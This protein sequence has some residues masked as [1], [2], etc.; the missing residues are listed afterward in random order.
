MLRAKQRVLKQKAEQLRDALAAL[1]ASSRKP[2]EKTAEELKRAQDLLNQA[3]QDMAAFERAMSE[4]FYQAAGYEAMID[5]ARNALGRA[6]R[7]LED[8]GD[9]LAEQAAQSEEEQLADK[10]EKL[11]AELA[12]LA[13][14]LETTVDPHVRDQLLVK[15]EQIKKLVAE[16][17]A[18]RLPYEN[19]FDRRPDPSA[20]DPGG[21]G[22]QSDTK[23][24]EVAHYMAREFWSKAIRA[25]KERSALGERQPSDAEYY[26]LEKEFFEDA[27][28]YTR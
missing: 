8:A 19:V 21:G 7:H 26:R 13:E 25:R 24:W 5:E 14:E 15:F 1:R 9:I 27:A 11:A 20:N 18:T 23:P 3:V 16:E 10:Y 28:K 2:R 12:R 4:V 6:T 22:D 17:M